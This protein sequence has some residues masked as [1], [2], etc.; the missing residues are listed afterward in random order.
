METFHVLYVAEELVGLV[1]QTLPQL[2][3]PHADA[4]IRLTSD[5]RTPIPPG[6]TSVPPMVASF[7]MYGELLESHLLVTRHFPSWV[8][9]PFRNQRTIATS[10]AVRP[11]TITAYRATTPEGMLA[12]CRSLMIRTADQLQLRYVRELLTMAARFGTYSDPKVPRRADCLAELLDYIR[13]KNESVDA[14]R[15]SALSA[16]R[17]LHHLTHTQ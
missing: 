13:L 12:M 10:N 16:D 4:E 8:T 1:E 9:G 3:I 7:T 15:D 11:G 2:G 5:S 17:L 14:Q 6:Y